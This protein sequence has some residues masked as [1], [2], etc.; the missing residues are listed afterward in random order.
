[1]Q[2]YIHRIPG[3]E[4]GT[5][6]VGHLQN[7]DKDCYYLITNHHVL[8]HE[9]DKSNVNITFEYSNMLSGKSSTKDTSGVDLISSA[10]VHKSLSLSGNWFTDNGTNLQDN[11]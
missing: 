2:Y 6:F 9:M 3:K 1:M 10:N 4:K 8:Q 7:N 5:G 11:V